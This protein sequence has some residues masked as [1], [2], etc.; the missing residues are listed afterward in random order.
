M[1]YKWD[2]QIEVEKMKIYW[3][4]VIS[5]LILFATGARA[6]DDGKIYIKIG[7]ASVKKSLIAVPPFQFL[8]SPAGAPNFKQT[9]VDLFNTAASSR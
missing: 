2:F 1:V 4:A 5:F 7:E 9:G 3:F 6:D 8:S